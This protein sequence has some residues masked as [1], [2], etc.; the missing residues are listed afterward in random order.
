MASQVLK[1]L[2]TGLNFR[3]LENQGP[4]ILFIV[5]VYTEKCMQLITYR[6]TNNQSELSDCCPGFVPLTRSGQR[7]LQS[8]RKL[9]NSV[10]GLNE[11]F[12]F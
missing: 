3:H 1:Y 9:F 8:E 7:C 10:C 2:G 4:S 12:F 5:S 11:V 6:L